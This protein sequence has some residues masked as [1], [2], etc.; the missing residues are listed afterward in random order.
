MDGASERAH[1]YLAGSRPSCVESVY[2]EVQALRLDW[3]RVVPAAMEEFILLAVAEKPPVSIA[4]ESYETLFR[5]Y[6]LVLQELAEG[7]AG[8][9]TASV[10]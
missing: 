2:K 10:H 9:W 7:W 4:G 3:M 1:E 6:G 8:G 5:G